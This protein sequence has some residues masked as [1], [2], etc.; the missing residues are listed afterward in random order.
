MGKEK[1]INKVLAKL[2][3]KIEI[4]EDSK[5]IKDNLKKINDLNKRNKL[6]NVLQDLPVLFKIRTVDIPITIDEK[7]LVLK[8]GEEYEVIAYKEGKFYVTNRDFKPGT[9]QLISWD[10]AERIK[11]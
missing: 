4:K 6:L 11:E 10:M 8:G 2:D 5:Q 3:Q 1:I 7:P 9:S